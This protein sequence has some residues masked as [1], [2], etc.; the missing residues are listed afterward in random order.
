MN[1]QTKSCCGR[2]LSNNKDKNMIE[3]IIYFKISSSGGFIQL[4]FV[5][6][7]LTE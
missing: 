7:Y 5:G 6:Q 3:N 4:R 2:E 1:L